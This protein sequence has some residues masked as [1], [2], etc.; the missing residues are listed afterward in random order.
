MKNRIKGYF[1]RGVAPGLAEMT[2][3]PEETYVTIDLATSP[4]VLDLVPVI[5][6]PSQFLS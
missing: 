2:Y 6:D 1:T 5:Y 3:H 4:S